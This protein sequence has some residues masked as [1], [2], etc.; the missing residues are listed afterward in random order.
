MT[1]SSNES[2]NEHFILKRID[3]DQIL[4]LAKVVWE[5]RNLVAEHMASDATR[6]ICEAYEKNPAFF[7]N[8][9]KKWVL[10]GLFYLVGRKMNVT[11]TQKHIARCLNTNEM[12][13]RNSCRE[14]L[15]H[16]PEFWPETTDH[17]EERFDKKPPLSPHSRMD[18]FL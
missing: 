5:G 9:S 3:H 6:L 7:G 11:R 1:D 2:T 8:R 17:L 4:G 14:W 12:T 10:G 16:F 18:K 13:I 15:R